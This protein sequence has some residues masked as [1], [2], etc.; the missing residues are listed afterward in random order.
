MEA[1]GVRLGLMGSNLFCLE[2]CRISSRY[3]E[4]TDSCRLVKRTAFSDRL[5]DWTVFAGEGISAREVPVYRAGSQVP[6]EREIVTSM[7]FDM[8]GGESW[9]FLVFNRETFAGPKLYFCREVPVYARAAALYFSGG[10]LR[11]RFRL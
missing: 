5:T 9:V 10:I 3:N 7:E 2:D 8:G 6:V 1:D 4:L 11:E